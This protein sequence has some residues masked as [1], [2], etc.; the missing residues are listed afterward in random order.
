MVQRFLVAAWLNFLANAQLP[1]S[2]HL[3]HEAILWLDATAGQTV[4]GSDDAWS[5]CDSSFLD[6]GTR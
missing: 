4:A 1:P 6:D 5:G 2:E 3:V